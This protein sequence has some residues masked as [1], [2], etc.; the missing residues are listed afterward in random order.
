M[1]LAA[2]LALVVASALLHP[3]DARAQATTATPASPAAAQAGPPIKCEG[4]DNTRVID[5][6]WANPT[7][8]YTRDMGG[9]GV[10]DALVIRFTTGSVS[11][12]KNLPRVVAA[13]YKSSPSSR[14]ATLSPKPCDFGPQPM[15]GSAGEGNSVTM[16]FAL[17]S[18][19]GGLHY[20]VLPLNT[21]YYVNIKNTPNATCESSGVCDMFV[22]LMKPTGM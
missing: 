20:A 6:D 1:Q 9:F 7:R 2:L 19:N 15:L 8:K 4:F 21:T 10:R 14:R 3:F 11:S 18:G 16:V 22:E 13:Q 17:G 12:E 5:L